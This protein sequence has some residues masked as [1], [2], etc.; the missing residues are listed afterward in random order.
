MPQSILNPDLV[1]SLSIQLY[2]AKWQC[3][4][5]QHG[6]FVVDGGCLVGD[7]DVV[8]LNPMDSLTV[9]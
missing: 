7:G 6:V 3:L 1:K 4:V 9:E 2:L 8:Y 5:L